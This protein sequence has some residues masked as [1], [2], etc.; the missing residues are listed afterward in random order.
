VR[1]A[2]LAY[3]IVFIGVAAYSPYLSLYYQSLGIS[4]GQIGA[5][6]AFTSAIALLSAPAW[7]AIHDRFP[8]SLILLPLAGSMAALGGF[9]LWRVGASPLLPVFAALFATGMAGTTP[10]MDVRVL[11]LAGSDRTR[12]GLVRA[13][14]SASFMVCAPLVGLLNEARGYQ[15]LFL[16]MVPALIAGGLMASAIPG[17]ANVA[18]AP[19]MVRAPGRVL[20]HRPI[21]LF[22][23]GSLVCWTA[24]YC[25]SSF[26]SIYLKSLG[27]TGDQVG[28][29]WSLGAVLEIPTMLSFPVLARRIGVERLILLGAGI[30]VAREIANVSFTNPSILLACSILQGAGY[31]LLVVGG[32]TFVSSRRRGARR[33]RP[34]DC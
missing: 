32:V 3:V 5:L 7:G 25:Q 6:L 27:A 17:R 15:A 29:A 8:R 26:F 23:I 11:E 12:Y 24:I 9:G 10:M 14:G 1:R 28:W 19:S 30:T 21:T 2:G 18:R 22:L 33:P 20:T 34:R 4:L 16:V 13:F 31:A